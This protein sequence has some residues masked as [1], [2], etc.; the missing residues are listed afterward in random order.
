[1]TINEIVA[2]VK[3]DYISV[4]NPKTKGTPTDGATEVVKAEIEFD[5]AD[6]V[7]MYITI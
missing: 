2:K 5:P 3:P 4:N 7:H 1:M 6:G